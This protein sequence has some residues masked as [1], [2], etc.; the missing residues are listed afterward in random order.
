MKISTKGEYYGVMQLEQNYGGILVTEYD[1]NMPVTDWHYHENPYFMYVLHGEVGD[2]NK[3]QK[4]HCSSGTLIFHNWQE[5]H[6][7][8]KESNNA[9]GFHIEFDRS[10][11]ARRKIDID[12]W[13]GT[14]IIENPKIHHLMAKLYSEFKLQDHLSEVSIEMLLFQI[15]EN[16]NSSQSTKNQKIPLWIDEL[17]EIL[18]RDNEDLSLKYLSNQLGVHPGHISRAI[19]KYLSSTLGGY[20]RQQKVKKAINLMHHSNHSLQDITYGCGFSDQSHFIRTF[21]SYMGM[22]PKEYRKRIG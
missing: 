7:N 5:A 2:I 16:I 11:F 9:R 19:P 14:Q 10:W 3:K 15:C 6:F 8:T 22:T 1:Y 4:R 12:L 20:I 17:K 13:E 18:H 21:K